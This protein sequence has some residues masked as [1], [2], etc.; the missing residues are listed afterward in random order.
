MLVLGLKLRRTI[1]YTALCTLLFEAS[2]EAQGLSHCVKKLITPLVE[3][4]GIQVKSKVQRVKE[5]VADQS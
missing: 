1:Q 5:D 3:P 4:C 2:R